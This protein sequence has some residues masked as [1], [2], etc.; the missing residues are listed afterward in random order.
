MT[1]KASVA[2]GVAAG[3]G[4]SS[5]VGDRATFAE[6]VSDDAGATLRGK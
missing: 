2:G 3:S 4:A 5:R 6:V 1:A